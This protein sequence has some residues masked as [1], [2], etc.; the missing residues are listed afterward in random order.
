MVGLEQELRPSWPTTEP[1]SSTTSWTCRS[2]CKR[3]SSLPQAQAV[4]SL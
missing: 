1:C 3:S 2:R 4:R